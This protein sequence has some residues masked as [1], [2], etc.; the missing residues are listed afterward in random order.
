MNSIF[1]SNFNG[2]AI[3]TCS[4]Y[5]SIISCFIVSTIGIGS[6]ISICYTSIV[7]IIVY[8]LNSSNNSTRCRFTRGW[9]ISLATIIYSIN[10]SLKRRYIIRVNSLTDNCWC[11]CKSCWTTSTFWTIVHIITS[12][13]YCKIISSFSNSLIN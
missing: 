9:P 5:S 4:C 7:S 10:P 6:T 13:S 1:A 8:I 3:S 2:T 11:I 12:S